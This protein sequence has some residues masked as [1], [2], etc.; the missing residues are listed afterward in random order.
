MKR[1]R[2]TESESESRECVGESVWG[3]GGERV[4]M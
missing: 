4:R 1:K 2:K 3:G